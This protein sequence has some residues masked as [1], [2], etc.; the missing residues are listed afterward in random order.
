MQVKT[1]LTLRYYQGL[2]YYFKPNR[3]LAILQGHQPAQLI[4]LTKQATRLRPTRML[5]CASA[6]LFEGASM[7]RNFVRA[8]SRH[9]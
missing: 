6:L 3:W 8:L 9:S 5:S 1:Y 7:P 2:D 4:A